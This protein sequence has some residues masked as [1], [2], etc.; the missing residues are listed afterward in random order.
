MPPFLASV[1]DTVVYFTPHS[2]LLPWAEREKTHT[3][4]HFAC[5]VKE[6]TEAVT[7]TL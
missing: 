3:H 1:M 7:S 2:V 5:H 4:T 6:L